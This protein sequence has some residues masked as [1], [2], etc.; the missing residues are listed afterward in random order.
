MTTG[1]RGAIVLISDMN[2]KEN[3]QSLV[4]NAEAESQKE[5]GVGALLK[6]EREKRSLNYGQLESMTM[7]RSYI[8]EA[9]E[10]E[11]WDK[12]PQPVFVRGFLKSYA[13]AIGLDEQKVMDLYESG[14][15]KFRAIRFYVYRCLRGST[16]HDTD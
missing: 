5:L 8:L 10:H 4:K 9:L 2:Q 16:F 6:N 15:S 13:R 12:L 3:Q 7:L 14:V 1:G 11:E